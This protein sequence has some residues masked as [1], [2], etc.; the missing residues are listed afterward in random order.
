MDLNIRVS[1]PSRFRAELAEVVIRLGAA[2]VAASVTYRTWASISTVAVSI[3]S[4]FN[5]SAPS[6][7]AWP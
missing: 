5:P 3:T 2:E 1:T 4:R 6:V 7:T